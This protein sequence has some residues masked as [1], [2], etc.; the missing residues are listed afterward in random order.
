MVQT[1]AMQQDKVPDRWGRYPDL[2]PKVF[3]V[4]YDQQMTLSGQILA[5]P[6]KEGTKTIY[7]PNSCANIANVVLS[8]I[9][10][11]ISNDAMDWI[12]RMTNDDVSNISNLVWHINI[13]SLA[14]LYCCPKKI[15]QLMAQQI[16]PNR[17]F[18]FF[19]FGHFIESFE[20]FF[21]AAKFLWKLFSRKFSEIY[22]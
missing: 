8:S 5:P 1:W 17:F 21:W 14:H 10:K 6:R 11:D 3:A 19:K 12:E 16:D 18:Y 4:W 7:D 15:T 20:L 22:L 9:A 13:N 2:T